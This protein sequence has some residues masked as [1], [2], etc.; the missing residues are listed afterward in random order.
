MIHIIFHF[1]V[2]QAKMRSFQALM[3]ERSLMGKFVFL[4]QTRYDVT[5]DLMIL[6]YTLFG[7]NSPLKVAWWTSKIS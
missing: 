4:D 3:D 6:G 5:K 2:A 1:K 7:K